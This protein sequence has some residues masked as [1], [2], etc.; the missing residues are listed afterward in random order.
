MSKT[1]PTDT[2]R[3]SQV[4][5]MAGDV[6]GNRRGARR[7]PIG[8]A[9]TPTFRRPIPIHIDMAIIRHQLLENVHDKARDR[10]RLGMDGIEEEQ[11]RANR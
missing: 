7:P 8:P 6:H 1:L 4:S 9:A 11:T 2:L 10:R 5:G 3:H